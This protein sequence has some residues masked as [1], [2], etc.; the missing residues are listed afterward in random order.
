[1]KNPEDSRPH[2]ASMQAQSG[3]LNEELDDAQLQSIAGGEEDRD[4]RYH[5]YVNYTIDHA[6]S[7]LTQAGLTPQQQIEQARAFLEGFNDWAASEDQS[8]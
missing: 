1:M 3:P 4:T 2:N 5:R 8:T 7:S 6:L